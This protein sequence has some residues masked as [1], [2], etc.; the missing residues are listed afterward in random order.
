MYLKIRIEFDIVREILLILYKLGTENPYCI[1]F[2]TGSWKANSR[3]LIICIP[4]HT[5]II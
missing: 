4:R 3:T 2:A 1:W 5:Y